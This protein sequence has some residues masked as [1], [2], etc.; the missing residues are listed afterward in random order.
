M[1]SDFLV[2]RALAFALFIYLW[3][4]WI[5]APVMAQSHPQDFPWSDPVKLAENAS[6]PVAVGDSSGK[7]HVF[8]VESAL[9]ASFDPSRQAVF[10][11]SGGDTTWSKPVDILVS[12]SATHTYVNA[13]VIDQ[14]GYLHLL[15]NDDQGLY[16]SSAPAS[17]AATPRQ[18]VTNMLISGQTPIGDMTQDEKGRLHVVARNDP[19]TLSYFHSDEHGANWSQS[20]IVETLES[21]GGKAIGDVRLAVGHDDVIHLTWTQ[22][23]EE[24]AWNFWSVWY[25]RST[26]G[27]VTWSKSELATPRFGGSDIAVDSENIVHL[28]YARNIGFPD[29]RWYQWSKDGGETWNQRQPLFPQLDYASGDTGGFDLVSDS[30]GTLYLANTVG[31][32]N[33]DAAAYL[34]NWQGDHWSA[35]QMLMDTSSHAH[36]ARL[37]LTLG[38]HLHFFAVDGHDYSLIYRSALTRAPAIAPSPLSVVTE[39]PAPKT[40]SP[41]EASVTSTSSVAEATAL[42]VFDSSAGGSSEL[43]WLPVVLG[44]LPAALVTV[45]AIIVKR[46]RASR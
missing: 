29:G 5:A 31:N 36:F 38:N 45:A 13:A 33:G 8:Y 46:S 25:A 44:V 6:G 23:A 9:D 7:V 40:P 26:D 42:P 1:K 21:S 43:P 15:W 2:L 14:E 27:G 34:L 10:Y 19:S 16:R 24:V 18:W 4:G 11:L 17:N 12:P 35:A 28:V 39:M 32:S 3:T 30:A 37:A 20:V 22:V 41:S